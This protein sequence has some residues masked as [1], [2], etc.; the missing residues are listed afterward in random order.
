MVA[1][2]IRSSEP[3]TAIRQFDSQAVD[4]L[5]IDDIHGQTAMNFKLFQM[6]QST[7]S[8]EI[9]ELESLMGGFKTKCE[10][11]RDLCNKI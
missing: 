2:D 10:V 7:K 1:V 6:L 5:A 3:L 11:S 4:V 8:E 9:A